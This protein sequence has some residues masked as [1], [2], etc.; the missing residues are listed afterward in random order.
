MPETTKIGCVKGKGSDN[1]IS[2]ITPSLL[3][4]EKQIILHLP[5]ELDGLHLSPMPTAKGNVFAVDIPVATLYLTQQSAL[6][7]FGGAKYGI[8]PDIVSQH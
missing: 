5:A 1:A 3:L 4:H 8:W 6:W 2:A 7:S